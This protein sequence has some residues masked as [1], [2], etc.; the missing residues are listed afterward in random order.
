M[1]ACV[2]IGASRGDWAKV[3]NAKATLVPV[4]KQHSCQSTA[5]NTAG[6][7]ANLAAW[8]QTRCGWPA[9]FGGG[10]R[11]EPSSIGCKPRRACRNV[12]FPQPL[13]PSRRNNS[14]ARMLAV[15]SRTAHPPPGLLTPSPLTSSTVPAPATSASQNASTSSICA[16]TPAWLQQWWSTVQLI[17]WHAVSRAALVTMVTGYPAVPAPHK[18]PTCRS[19]SSRSPEEPVQSQLGTY[20]FTPWSFPYNPSIT[21]K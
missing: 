3:V 11:T 20:R 7:A 13:G 1:L 4:Q 15:R 2:N 12:V 16:G 8:R 14:P 5:Q 19:L 21:F 6:K 18:P 17:A 9:W 10:S